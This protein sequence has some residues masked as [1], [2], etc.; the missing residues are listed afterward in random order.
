MLSGIDK[1]E[2]CGIRFIEQ[3]VPLDDSPYDSVSI[4]FDLN[5]FSF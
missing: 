1:L 4:L 2:E 5:D 3:R